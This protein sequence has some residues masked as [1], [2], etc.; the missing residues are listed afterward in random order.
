MGFNTYSTS[1]L[2]IFSSMASNRGFDFIFGDYNFNNLSA[3]FCKFSIEYSILLIG[4]VNA[5]FAN[6]FAIISFLV[7]KG[8]YI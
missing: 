2:L 1:S 6:T 3:S 5:F 7:P 4:A 8:Y